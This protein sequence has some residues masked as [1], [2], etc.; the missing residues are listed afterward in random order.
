M[1]YFFYGPQRIL[2]RYLR[3]VGI[4]IKS[5]SHRNVIVSDSIDVDA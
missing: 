3:Y 5:W 4:H 1:V 2:H